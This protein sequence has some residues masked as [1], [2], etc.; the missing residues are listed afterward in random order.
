MPVIGRMA[1][2]GHFYTL[3][4][5]FC[6]G[7]QSVKVALIQMILNDTVLLKL[8]FRKGFCNGS[9]DFSLIL[10]N[11]CIVELQKSVQFG[12]PI[13]HG[14]HSASCSEPWQRN[15]LWSGYRESSPQRWRKYP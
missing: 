15:P 12:G 4:L 5:W 9:G 10:Q 2:N 1:D 11:L 6:A 8:A 14:R 7:Y 13:C 3:V